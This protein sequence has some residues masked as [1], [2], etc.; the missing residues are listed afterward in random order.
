[1]RK[2]ITVLLCSLSCLGLSQ[3]NK[4][5][6]KSDE[7]DKAVNRFI[8]ETYFKRLYKYEPS[9]IQEN[10]IETL[11]IN[12]KRKTEGSPNSSKLK[13]KVLFR[14]DGRPKQMVEW[15]E[16]YPTPTITDYSYDSLGNLVEYRLRTSPGHPTGT[17]KLGREIEHLF[18]TY[19]KNQLTKTFSYSQRKGY[20]Y[21]TLNYC[22]SLSF[23]LENKKVSIIRGNANDS[24]I[25][26]KSKPRFI[27]PIYKKKVNEFVATDP[28]LVAPV[29]QKS[30]WTQ[31]CAYSNK[32]LIALQEI[33]GLQCLNTD[34]VNVCK[35]VGVFWKTDSAVET[36]ELIFDIKSLS[37]REDAIYVDT[38][39]KTIYVKTH[40]FIS[41]PT[42]L[43]NRNTSNETTQ[44]YDYSLIL[45]QTNEVRES[46]RGQREY[47]KDSTQTF[48]TY[49]DF[50]LVQ[51]KVE[52]SYYI[53]PRSD[54]GDLYIPEKKYYSVSTY[55]EETELK[56]W[57]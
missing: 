12:A 32:T 35:G 31:S 17:G 29:G 24:K 7:G 28:A 33:T 52:S 18:F 46:S 23:Q 14:K 16:H 19:N 5:D 47:I 1:M 21:L 51:R 22:D 42:S 10:K 38:I 49:Y 40:F 6:K 53:R 55:E 25:I 44:I 30:L 8:Y 20:D 36:P 26:F 48:F 41:E 45:R 54:S 50:G 15:Y 39:T 57:E 27:Y 13:Q 11:T 34:I 3:T 43:E 2:L 4:V 56:T 9:I 37:T